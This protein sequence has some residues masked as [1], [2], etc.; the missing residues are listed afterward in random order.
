MFIWCFKGVLCLFRLANLI[1]V[2]IESVKLK[3]A[4][5]IVRLE[6]FKFENRDISSDFFQDPK[7]FWSRLINN[8]YTFKLCVYSSI[9]IV[10]DILT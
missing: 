2:V 4:L 10:I 5:A 9:E 3:H 6:R 7:Q 1:P 8:N